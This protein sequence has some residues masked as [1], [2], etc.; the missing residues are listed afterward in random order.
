MKNAGGEVDFEYDHSVYWPALA[1]LAAERRRE[2]TERW[3]KA[4]KIIGES[5][6]Y[7]WGGQEGS[8]A[9]APTA[10]ATA[11]APQPSA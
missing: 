11:A 10:T 2:R 8:L 7:L 6:V 3:E 1:N 9:A 4:G 5:E